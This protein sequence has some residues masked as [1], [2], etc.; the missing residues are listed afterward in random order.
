MS[1]LS[2][3]VGRETRLQEAPFTKL[4][5]I[6]KALVTAVAPYLD[7]PF[8]FFGHRMGA[9]VS[10]E[11][12]RELR[13]R[14]LPQP[15]Q[16][17]VSASRAPQCV[18]LIDDT[19][20]LN[21][22]DF[23]EKVRRQYNGLSPAVLSDPELLGLVLPYMRADFTLI[24]EYVYVEEP[25]FTFPI[26]CFGGIDDSTVPQTDLGAWRHHTA[27]SFCLRLFPG[28]HFFLRERGSRVVNALIASLDDSA[29][30]QL[31]QY[32]QL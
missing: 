3:R 18:H 5:D 6:V 17:I 15:V 24:E 7:L 11:A 13:R 2:P 27:A 31:G 8:A 22:H 16:L 1:P 10:F 30:L 19:H 32:L 23:L 26:T 20:L 29:R 21:D 9:V 14:G 4:A 25:P 12:S 28:G